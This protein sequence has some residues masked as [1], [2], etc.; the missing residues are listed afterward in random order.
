MGDLTRELANSICALNKLLFGK[1]EKKVDPPQQIPITLP[2]EGMPQIILDKIPEPVPE[3]FSLPVPPDIPCK[4]KIPE[5]IVLPP[6]PPLNLCQPTLELKACKEAEIRELAYQKW[7]QA[8]RPEGDGKNFWLE[9][10]KEVDVRSRN[11]WKQFAYPV[12]P[13][14]PN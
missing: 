11:Y 6:L 2:P 10:E 7:E 9:A 4:I 12:Y 8:G 3:V 13:K 1:K 14:V 5:N